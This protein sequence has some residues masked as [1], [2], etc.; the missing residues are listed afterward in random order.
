[1][2]RP[3]VFITKTGSLSLHLLFRGNRREIS[4]VVVFA[5][6]GDGFQIFGISPVGDADACDL[7]LLRHGNGFWF[8][9]EGFVGKLVS[10]DPAALFH[11]PDDV[12]GV[13]ICLRN[14]IQCLLCKFLSIHNHH[15]FALSVCQRAENMW[16]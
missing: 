7:S 9:N 13:G 10:R 12:F 16:R 14:L 3:P 2:L 8:G 1:M 4:E 5:A 6:V 11:K 15:S